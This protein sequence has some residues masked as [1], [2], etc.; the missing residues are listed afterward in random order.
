[1][2]GSGPTWNKAKR[3]AVAGAVAPFIRDAAAGRGRRKIYLTRGDSVVGETTLTELQ[4]GLCRRAGIELAVVDGARPLAAECKQCGAVFRVP[5]KGI[6]R[7]KCPRC[8]MGRCEDCGEPAPGARHAIRRGTPVRC[9]VCSKKIRRRSTVT[10]VECGGPLSRSASAPA[11][12]ASRRGPPR[13]R[14][15]MPLGGPQGRPA[16]GGAYA[17]R[18]RFFLRVTIAAGQRRAETL[19]WVTAAQ[20]TAHGTCKPCPC[21]ACVRAR[22]VQALVTRYRDGGA[23]IEM[24]EGL[25]KS[26]A[27][28]DAAKLA[29]IG[30]AVEGFC[31]GRLW[32][33]A[34]GPTRGI[35]PAQRRTEVA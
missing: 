33:A 10:C 1:M 7:D 31:E 30:R 24:L 3:L 25:V 16:H 20:W 5:Q 4:L 23:D 14:K 26:A 28:S 9:A 15:C 13:C 17:A 35:A 22:E 18:G 29:A 2:A 8:L 19:S 32:K 34:R 6:V 21:V 27:N 12:R 11:V